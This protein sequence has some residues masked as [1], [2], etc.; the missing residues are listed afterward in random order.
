MDGIYDPFQYLKR[1]LNERI[2]EMG[3]DIQ[4]VTLSIYKGNEKVALDYLLKY[5]DVIF[6]DLQENLNEESI[7]QYQ[8]L[9]SV[10]TGNDTY[11]D[12]N[13]K[14]VENTV[15]SIVILHVIVKLIELSVLE[16]KSIDSYDE[17]SKIIGEEKCWYRGQSSI[18][19]KLVPSFYRSLGSKS[20]HVNKKYLFN[21]YNRMKIID[22]INSV[23]RSSTLTYEQL[24]FIQHSMAFSP[25]LD[26]TTDIYT[27]A[28]FAVSNHS[29][30]YLMH[31]EPAAIFSIKLNGNEDIIRENDDSDSIIN[32]L[33]VEYI[34]SKPYISTLIKSNM[35]IDL[36]LGKIY[37]E[38]KLI[39]IKTND[40][41]RIQNGT[42]VL[43]NNVLI[44]GDDMVV[45]TRTRRTMS[46]I[47]TKYEIKVDKGQ[48][49][50][51]YSQIM[52][53]DS[54]YHL[55]FMMNPYDYMNH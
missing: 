38:Y 46:K 30:P 41:M 24:A 27:A 17:L 20:V 1:I 2:N 26:F 13:E 53:N 18:K 5:E 21:E 6:K 40:R 23:F 11:I 3:R 28:S 12:L 49:Y 25:L 51:I 44:I 37:S 14:S 54:K 31:D 8:S 47:I 10:L 42:F 32:N 33:N 7:Q 4:S 36:I 43:F 9:I 45:S 22:R 34:G 48:R 55:N 29:K 15:N 35:W 19:W 50:R 16:T 39:D 52:A